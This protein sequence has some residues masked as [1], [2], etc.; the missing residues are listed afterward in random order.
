MANELTKQV[1][2][3]IVA[4]CSGYEP[5]KASPAASP[6][7]RG[8]VGALNRREEALLSQIINKQA[9]VDSS[10]SGRELPSGGGK[11]GGG[12]GA[13]Q[14]TNGHSQRSFNALGKNG[15]VSLDAL[16]KEMKK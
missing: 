13:A 16:I 5:L 4:R 1:M 2:A 3:T 6:S 10:L 12:Q 14:T 11:N 9:Q 7:A 15:V 8:G